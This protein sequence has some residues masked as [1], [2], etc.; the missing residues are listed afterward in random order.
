MWEC[1]ITVTGVVNQSNV[2]N[3]CRNYYM[4]LTP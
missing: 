2:I 1:D 4:I 3:I